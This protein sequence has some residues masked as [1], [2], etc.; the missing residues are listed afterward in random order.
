[1]GFDL[2]TV[3]DAFTSRGVEYY[4]SFID[5]NLEEAY[6][7]YKNEVFDPNNIYSLSTPL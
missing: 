7:Q 2:S 3:D 6:L 5:P 4:N 1:V